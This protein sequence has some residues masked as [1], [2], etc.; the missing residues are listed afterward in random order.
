MRYYIITV[1]E[2]DN[3]FDLYEKESITTENGL[4][5]KSPFQKY[6]QKRIENYKLSKIIINHQ[7]YINDY[8][9]E[10]EFAED[11]FQHNFENSKNK[12]QKNMFYHPDL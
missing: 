9:T 10:K 4:R 11:N 8:N 3:D 2:T 6:F 7:D 1:E 5:E 12:I